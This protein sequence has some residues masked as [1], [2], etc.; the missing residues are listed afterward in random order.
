MTDLEAD[1]RR[2]K[3]AAVLLDDP[4]LKEAF[5]SLE[6]LE[7]EAL[8]SCPPD[9]LQERRAY[10]AGVRKLRETLSIFVRYGPVSQRK[11]DALNEPE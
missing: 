3:H 6:K 11:I 1:V 10:V 7:I 9:E 8:I 2:A 4:V 5:D